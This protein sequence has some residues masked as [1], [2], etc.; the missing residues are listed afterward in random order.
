MNRASTEK[1]PAKRLLAHSF[2][3]LKDIHVRSVFRGFFVLSY[4]PGD[5]M[6]ERSNLKNFRK[7]QGRGLRSSFARRVRLCLS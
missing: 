5:L 3:G 1:L 7:P 2:L 4:R 6:L